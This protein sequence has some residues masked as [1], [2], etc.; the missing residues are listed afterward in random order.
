M[1]ED[2]ESAPPGWRWDKTINLGHLLTTISAL[3]AAI[4]V[5][6]TFH[7]RLAIV[8]QQ[9]IVQKVIDDNL[10]EDALRFKQ[11]MRSD[12]REILG[13]LDRLNERVTKNNHD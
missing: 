7:T 12:L 2:K 1:I 9:L 11:D 5:G 10:K 4:V 3:A 13:K 8:E 6:S